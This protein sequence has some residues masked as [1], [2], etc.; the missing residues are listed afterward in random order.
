MLK[1]IKISGYKSLINL[2][3]KLEPLSVLFGPNAAGKSN[4]LDALL[5]LS[6]MAKSRTLKEAFEPPYRG[7]ALESFTFGPRGTKGLL[8][9]KNATFSIEADVEL[10]Q[11]IV[12]S[13]NRQ[14]IEMRRR[15]T[16]EGTEARSDISRIP[17]VRERYLRYRIVVE[18]FPKS[19][20][21]RVKDEYLAALNKGGEPKSSRTAFLEK[22]GNKLHLRM[23]RQSHPIYQDCHLDHT[24]LSTPLYAPHFPHLV[25]MRQ[26]LSSW[27][28]FYFE[29]RE[30][31]RAPNPVKEVRHIG[32]MGEELA[33]FLNTLK[34]ID[35]L[36]FQA[37]EKSLRLLIPEVS[38]ILVEVSDQGEVELKLLE[39]D[40][41]IPARVLSE[42]TLRMLGLLALGG[43]KEPPSLIGFEEP[44][45]GVHPR[46][47]K[48]IA[49]YLLTSARSGESQMIIT[50]HS[51]TLPDLIPKKY[52]FVCHKKKKSTIIKPF[53][54]WG[55]LPK[56]IDIEK[57]LDADEEESPVSERIFRGDFDA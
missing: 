8:E 55:E 38:K 3:V 16:E 50:T 40:T 1:R 29:P 24:V 56:R 45:N 27:Y 32:L 36:Q 49:E 53:L 34:A 46:R 43:A 21:L 37:V 18:I 12:E 28:F 30:R 31:M 35:N 9:Q 6:R 17:L 47:I 41:P 57:A 22:I 44:E 2:D 14:I 25:A 48:M 23:E 26:E 19:G 52:L 20:I 10:S 42:G 7:K 33:C 5:L 54:T 13:V 39:K 51:P 11:V 4:F 15:G